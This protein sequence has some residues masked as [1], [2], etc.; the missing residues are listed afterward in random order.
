M[1]LIDIIKSSILIFT[2]SILLTVIIAFLYSKIRNQAKVK[3]TTNNKDLVQ[4]KVKSSIQLLNKGN[5]QSR[6]SDYKSERAK[7]I[8]IRK[9]PKFMVVNRNQKADFSQNFKIEY[10][11]NEFTDY[12]DSN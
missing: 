2:S 9:H 3:N 12:E 8:L 7:N 5:V 1:E 4:H 6:K 11:H 10:R